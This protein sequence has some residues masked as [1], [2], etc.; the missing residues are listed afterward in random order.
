MHGCIGRRRHDDIGV[1]HTVS[2]VAPHG[3]LAA[4][5]ERDFSRAIRARHN[6]SLGLCGVCGVFLAVVDDHAANVTIGCV[7]VVVR[8]IDLRGLARLGIVARHD[9][10]SVKGR[11]SRVV[12]HEVHETGSG[13]GIEH[14]SGVGVERREVD[15]VTVCNLNEGGHVGGYAVLLVD[16]VAVD[17]QLPDIGDPPG[18]VGGEAALAVVAV[19]HVGHE[20]RCVEVV[21]PVAVEVVVASGVVAVL[22]EVELAGLC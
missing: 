18:V 15:A 11:V 3:P 10:G 8:E 7:G 19:G 12:L 13:V 16:D 20:L 4:G 17:A 6:A 5:R 2:A 1:L 21:D 14:P 22:L 9:V